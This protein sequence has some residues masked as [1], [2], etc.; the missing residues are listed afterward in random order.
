[1][2][3]SCSYEHT[4]QETSSALGSHWQ[5][6]HGMISC[7]LSLELKLPG[8]IHFGICSHRD[9]N[10]GNTHFQMQGKKKKIR[11]GLNAINLTLKM[12]YLMGLSPPVSQCQQ[13]FGCINQL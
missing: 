9:V 1:M 4:S 2:L 7:G 8:F 3:G 12:Q 11:T 10:G 6:S 5:Q 13:R